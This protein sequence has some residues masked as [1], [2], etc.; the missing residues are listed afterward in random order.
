MTRSLA[1]VFLLALTKS[2]SLIRLEK[3][4]KRGMGERRKGLSLFTWGHVSNPGTG[5]EKSPDTLPKEGRSYP[6]PLVQG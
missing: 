3:K 1:E 5:Q 2:P 6:A 4:K